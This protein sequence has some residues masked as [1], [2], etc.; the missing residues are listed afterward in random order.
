[1]VPLR[2]QS[3]LVV[4]VGACV[5]SGVHAALVHSNHTCPRAEHFGVLV[6]TMVADTRV[7][8]RKRLNPLLPG[9]D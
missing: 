9:I 4:N 5:H 3:A 2:S 1:M 7:P 6:D 8:N